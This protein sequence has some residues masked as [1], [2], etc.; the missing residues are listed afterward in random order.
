MTLAGVGVALADQDFDHVDDFSN[1]VRRLG[2]DIGRVYSQSAD[3]LL[4]GKRKA[5]GERRDVFAI[6]GC[7]CVDL[8]V[9]VRDVADVGDARVARAQ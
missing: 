1:V 9:N 2:Y 7:G 8:I 4:V 3:V 6:F 5:F